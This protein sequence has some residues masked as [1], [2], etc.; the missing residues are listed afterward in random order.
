MNNENLGPAERI[1][2]TVLQYSDHMV[3]NRPGMVSPDPTSAAGV[4]WTYVKWKEENGVKVVY[5]QTKVGKKITK[6]RRGTLQGNLV[7]NDA[8]ARIGEYRKPGFF[9]EVAAW[10]YKQVADVWQMDNE[11]AARWAS[12]A[13][14]QEHRDMKVVLAA[15]MMVQSR[16]G[17]PILENGKEVFRDEDYRNVGEAM[18]LLNRPAPKDP[19]DKKEK[20][21]AGMDAKLLL[22]IREFLDLPQIAQINRDLKFTASARAP[23]YGRWPRAVA[24]WLLYRE[25][26]PKLFA[27]L[28]KNGFRT[29]IIELAIKS[30]YK[31]ETP[32]FFEALR[33]KQEQAEAGHRAVALDM[34]VT[35]AES[36]N[37]LTEEQVCERISRDKPGIKRIIGLLPKHLGMTKAIMAAAIEAGS[38]S[39]KDLI[40]A[41]PT[42]EELGL[43]QDETVKARWEKAMK[44]TDDMRAANIAT[45]VKSKETKEKLQD[46]AD[47]ALKAQVAEVMKNMRVYFYVDVSGSMEKAIEAA[48][49][50]IAR[51]AQG[52]PLDKLHAATFN[53]VGKVIEIKHA[54]AAGVENAFRGTKAVGGT[55]HE[56]GIRALAG[57][58]PQPDEDVL[59]IFVGDEQ[60]DKF[61]DAAV[62][63]SGL[64]PMAFGFV[65]LVGSDGTT[66]R[67]VQGTA[68]R[69]GIPCFLIDERTFADPYAIPRTIR[70]LVAATPV[71][72]AVAAQPAPQRVSLVETIL[73]T[74]LLQK[75]QWAA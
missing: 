41:T 72:Q 46:A 48:K 65:K 15:F 51:F 10:L 7:V 11:F 55:S 8:G 73:K 20:N 5:E 6:T 66:R 35:A 19:K 43:L 24:K 42:L 75:P 21:P 50:H 25:Q 17:D 29:T 61:F 68:Q 54:S 34:A 57:F 12:Y 14:V 60:E 33:W 53:T 74:P 56:S 30:G 4:K 18:V 38:L 40:I 62:R 23:Q 26:N 71:N 22:R 37:D 59:F 36:W 31:P 58:K 64:N 13:W 16:K 2:Q 39:S 44:E 27:G 1:I 49:A 47:T 32:K 9:P 52:F 28:L 70:A 45:R 3:H 69:L 67:A 63:Q